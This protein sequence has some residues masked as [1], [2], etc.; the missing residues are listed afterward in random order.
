[1][2]RR[3]T[4]LPTAAGT[5]LA[6]ASAVDAAFAELA[7]GF[8]TVTDEAEA[9][10]MDALG[11]SSTSLSVLKDLAAKRLAGEAGNSPVPIMVDSRRRK[12]WC[13][14]RIF[15]NLRM[16]KSSEAHAV[17]VSATRPLPHLQ[18]RRWRR[19][20]GTATRCPASAE[21]AR[22]TNSFRHR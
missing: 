22:G 1:M 19:A 21:I 14:V 7:C 6:R 16:P 2:K 4:F 8:S 10:V 15:G 13:L 11:G 17:Q 20:R 5:L 12:S 3:R 9:V 18:R